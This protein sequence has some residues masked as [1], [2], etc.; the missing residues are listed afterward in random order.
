MKTILLAGEDTNFLAALRNI[1]ADAEYETVLVRNFQQVSGQINKQLPDLIIL[2]VEAVDASL[3]HFCKRLRQNPATMDVKLIILGERRDPQEMPQLLD[4]GADLY[5]SKPYQSSE[6]I[7][8]IRALLRRRDTVMHWKNGSVIEIDLAHRLLKVN[9]RLV[10]LTPMEF[11]LMA[12]LCQASEEYLSAQLLLKNVWRYPDGS[13][14]T[15]LVRNHIRNL[16]AKIE[17]DSDRPR[18][19]ESL[20]KRGYR[21]NGD[22]RWVEAVSTH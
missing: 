14:D 5:L 2:D 7:A 17:D 18:I 9:G 12:Y 21:I 6:L 13:G 15:A 19:I 11:D 20:P 4:A 8:R 10:L 22:V 3:L 1:L 16:R